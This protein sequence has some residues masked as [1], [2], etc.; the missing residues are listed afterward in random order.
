M[1]AILSALQWVEVSVN[2]PAMR[3]TLQA[4][5]ISLQS[6]LQIQPTVNYSIILDDSSERG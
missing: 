6:M 3:R 2:K 5:E 1:S 4:L